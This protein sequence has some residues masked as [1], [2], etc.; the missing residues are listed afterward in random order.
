VSKLRIKKGGEMKNMKEGISREK[1]E[2]KKEKQK[3]R[4]KERESNVKESA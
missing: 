1:M 3:E 2:R 4:E